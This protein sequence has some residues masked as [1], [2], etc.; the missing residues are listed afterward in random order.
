MSYFNTTRVSGKQKAQYTL[1]AKAQE[2]EIQK[3]FKARSHQLFTPSEVLSYLQS[4]LSAPPPI[5]SV[6]RAMTNLTSLGI[7]M[8]TPVQKLGP[9]NRPEY[10]WKYNFGR[11]LSDLI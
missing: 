1:K 5:T 3:F 8:K 4:V 7:L 6:R 9:Y 10:C 2:D 11:D